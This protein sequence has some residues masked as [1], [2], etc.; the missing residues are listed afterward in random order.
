MPS[1]KKLSVVFV[2]NHSCLLTYSVWDLTWAFCN[3]VERMLMPV[4]SLLI[5]QKVLIVFEIRKNKQNSVQ[6]YV[7]S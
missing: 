2:I 3:F 1:S 6:I 5:M 4:K 7:S